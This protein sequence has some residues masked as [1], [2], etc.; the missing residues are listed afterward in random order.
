MG[1]A[2][3]SQLPD[4]AVSGGEAPSERHAWLINSEAP[5]PSAG[6]QSQG[7]GAHGGSQPAAAKEPGWDLGAWRGSRLCPPSLAPAALSC[8][9]RDSSPPRRGPGPGRL[10]PLHL[11]VKTRPAGRPAMLS[12]HRSHRGRQPDPPPHRGSATSR[13][14]TSSRWRRLAGPSQPGLPHLPDRSY[15]HPLSL[16]LWSG[17]GSL[18]TVTLSCRESG[19][20]RRFSMERSKHDQ[21]S[22]CWETHL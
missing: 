19:T 21:S 9:A 12:V 1:S 7:R 22:L 15:R 5:P 10:S 8:S 6:C 17:G 13:C 11:G 20:C 14:L 4:K 18:Q 3:H 16:R 2:N